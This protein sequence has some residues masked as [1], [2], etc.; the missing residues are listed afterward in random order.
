[1]QVEYEVRRLEIS[2]DEVISK[3]NSLGAKKIGVFHQKRYVYDFIPAQK[4]RW[5]RLRTNGE[6]ITLTIKE[7]QS[8]D[9]DGTKEL[10]IVVSDF[11]KTND[12]LNKLGY[13]ARTFQE[14]FRIEYNFNGVNIDL[15]KWPMIP[16]YMEIEGNSEKDVYLMMKILGIEKKDVTSKDVD[17]I[18]KDC[19]G[20][21]LDEI[22][23]LKFDEA[24]K[25]YIKTFNKID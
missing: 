16:M 19:Y 20:I 3:L 18:Y 14:N 2:F 10:E 7:I 25:Q 1:M 8:S 23:V 24:E 17:S 6:K 22:K 21:D 5:I 15:D 13:K 9:I 12:I 11:D 4:G